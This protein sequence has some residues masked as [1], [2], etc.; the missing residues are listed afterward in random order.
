MLNLYI[1]T[2]QIS[3]KFARKLSTTWSRN[4]MSIAGMDTHVNK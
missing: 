2:S 4:F 3:F 1:T